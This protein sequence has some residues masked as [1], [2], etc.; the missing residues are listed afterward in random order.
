[1]SRSRVF[2]LECVR[3]L[4]SP[5]PVTGAPSK[6]PSWGSSSQKQNMMEADVGELSIS[7]PTDTCDDDR[8]DALQSP[9]VLSA[10]MAQVPQLAA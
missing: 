8:E 6:L 7:S 5:S 4:M 2:I 1:M 10:I 3:T 9:D